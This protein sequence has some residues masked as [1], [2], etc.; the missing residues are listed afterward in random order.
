M[1]MCRKQYI[2]Q[3]IHS[4]YVLIVKPKCIYTLQICDTV[5]KASAVRLQLLL[6]T[7]DAYII[8][9]CM[10]HYAIFMPLI[11]TTTTTTR[12]HPTAACSA[13]TRSLGRH[14]GGIFGFSPLFFFKQYFGFLYLKIHKHLHLLLCYK[15]YK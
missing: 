1:C 12:T 7:I 8:R 2:N 11:T 6:R 13:S 5:K 15:L 10:L 9:Y 3:R 14:S 4:L